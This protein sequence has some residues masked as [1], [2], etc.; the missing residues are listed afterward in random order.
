MQPAALVAWTKRNGRGLYVH[1]GIY[2][3]MTGIVLYGYGGW[4]WLPVLAF[5]SISHFL[6]DKLKYALGDRATGRYVWYF[7]LDQVLHGGVIV[8][9]A[10]SLAYLTQDQLVSPPFI[11]LTAPYVRALIGMT[12]LVGGAFGGSILVFESVRT[13]AGGNDQNVISFRDRVPGIIE[14]GTAGA[15]LFLTPVVWLT[16][17]PFAY[18]AGRVIYFWKTDKRRRVIVELIAS[19]VGFAMA[20]G[21]FYAKYLL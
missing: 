8:I 3:L 21:L 15:L 9:A 5:M 12:A 17:L 1:V 4:L 7:L 20:C 6:F 2:T 19:L 10:I 16:P 14:R 11:A 18:S 13:F